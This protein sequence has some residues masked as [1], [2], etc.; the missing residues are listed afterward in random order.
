MIM[1]N[2][3]TKFCCAVFWT[4]RR[5]LRYGIDELFFASR[6]Q[7]L[8]PTHALHVWTSC[9]L[10]LMSVEDMDWEYHVQEQV[11]VKCLDTFLTT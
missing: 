4:T 2:L 5:A 8:L 10:Q 3:F 11:T 1:H 9:V 7:W 6:W